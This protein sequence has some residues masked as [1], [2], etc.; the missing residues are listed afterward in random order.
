[1]SSNPVGWLIFYQIQLPGI[2][3]GFTGVHRPQLGQNVLPVVVHRTYTDAKVIGNIAAVESPGD[4]SQN[5]QLPGGDGR[6]RSG[7][8]GGKKNPFPPT[9]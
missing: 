8:F 9:L 4:K 5:L 7:F 3:D 2:M 6:I 1:M